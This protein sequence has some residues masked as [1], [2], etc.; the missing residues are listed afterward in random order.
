MSEKENARST[1]ATVKRAEAA[2]FSGAA[3]SRLYSTTPA[4]VCQVAAHLPVGASV[5]LQYIL[6]K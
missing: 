2:V 4:S 5:G 1:A 3:A 6:D